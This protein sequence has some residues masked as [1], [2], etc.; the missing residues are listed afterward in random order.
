MTD[1]LRNLIDRHWKELD[2]V[3]VSAERKLRVAELPV[4]TSRGKLA[5]AV[6]LDGHRHVLVP[7]SSN[8]AVRRGLDGPALM[9]RKRPLEG[10]NTYQVY[11][12]LGCLRSDLNDLF[13][14]VCADVLKTTEAMPEN[15]L[16]A[17]HRVLDRWKSLF[18]TVGAP[19]GPEQIAGL[20]GELVV[21]VQLLQLDSSAHR[22]WL[23]PS[24]N[25]HDFSNGRYA[26]EVKAFTSSSA[27]ARRVRIHGLDQLDA[28][29]GGALKLAWLRLER[30]SIG[31]GKGF[32]ELIERALELCDDESALMN[33]LSQVGYHAADVDFYREVRYSLAEERWYTVDAGFPKLTLAELAAGAPFGVT[34][35]AYTIDFSTEPPIPLEEEQVLEHL[36]RM[37]ESS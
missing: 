21:L 2:A 17:L 34:D 14:M 10:E 20:F 35:V 13:T 28:P 15:P 26:I 29:S 27:D 19:L 11:A 6:D 18:R 8:Q 25:H 23:G 16:K 12:D 22:L 33:L 1:D 32:V 31:G 3:P 5:V 30:V 24:G 37:A 36:A 9:L 7:I 4:D